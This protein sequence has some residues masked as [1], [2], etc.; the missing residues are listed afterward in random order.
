M[1]EVLHCFSADTVAECRKRVKKA[2]RKGGE[3]VTVGDWT[4]DNW[5][6]RT[7]EQWDSIPEP[8]LIEVCA[9]CDACAVCM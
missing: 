4:Q 1:E 3:G 5:A 8:A 7:L 2:A 9:V 6:V